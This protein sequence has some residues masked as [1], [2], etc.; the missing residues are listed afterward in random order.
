MMDATSLLNLLGGYFFVV[1]LPLLAL[2]IVYL[3]LSRAFHEMGFSSWEA[4]VIVFVSFLL[5]SGLADGIAR[6]RFSNITLF[7]YNTYWLVGVNVGGALIPLAL[8]VYLIVKNKIRV[9]PV[10]VGIVPVA[11]I[12]YL[13]TYTDPSQGIV[14]EFPYWLIPVLGA[15]LLSVVFSKGRER[16]AAPFAY[17]IG[18][19]GVLIGADILHLFDLLSFPIHTSTNAVIGGASVFDMVFI[20]GVLAVF[21]DSIFLYQRKRRGTSSTDE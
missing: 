17:T 19:L 13:V 7:T 6:I 16:I 21:L 10:V 9:A 18:T 20:T 5:G 14:A 12:T 4:V 1:F 15:S 8:S 11:M 2:Y 3:I